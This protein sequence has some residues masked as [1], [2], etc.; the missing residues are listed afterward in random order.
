[1]Y[2]TFRELTKENILELVTPFQIFR[3]YIP[4]FETGKSIKTPFKQESR[5]SF[6]TKVHPDGGI[7]FHDFGRGYTGD[8]FTLVR[9]LHGDCT[10]QEALMLINRDMNLGLGMSKES[11]VNLDEH[12]KRL[13]EESFIPEETHS[14][15][16]SYR[17]KPRTMIDY[18]YWGLHGTI[19]Y[20]LDVYRIHSISAFWINGIRYRTDHLAYSWHTDVDKIKIYQPYNQGDFKWRSNTN[21]EH[22]Q[23]EREL[24]KK[25]RTL[26]IQSSLKDITCVASR[27]HIPG[28]APNGEHGTIPKSKLED[29]EQRFDRIA[30]LYDN[31]DEG[32][33]AAHRVVDEYNYEMLVL[34]KL[35]ELTK[36]PSDFMFHGY[37]RQLNQF[38]KENKLI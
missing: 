21:N 31:D 22:L 16:I 20:M 11:I 38:F 35:S 36:D 10:F 4:W 29:Y 26:L 8:C 5:P 19:P 15:V 30:V 14:A 24:P 37:V 3:H 2:G 12:L 6:W 32:I 9:K 33:K 17:V 7:W 23:G 28:V 13:R 27:Y 18:M 1:M 25:G 34:P